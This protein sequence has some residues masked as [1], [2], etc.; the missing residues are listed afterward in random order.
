MKIIPPSRF[1]CKK[2]SSPI[3]GFNANFDIP[4]QNLEIISNKRPMGH[5]A[6]P[7]KQFISINTY[8]YSVFFLPIGTGTGTHSIGKIASKSNKLGI[9]CQCTGRDLSLVLVNDF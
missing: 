4:V 7:R 8:D 1:K 5:I 3:S 9:F 2:N 6:H